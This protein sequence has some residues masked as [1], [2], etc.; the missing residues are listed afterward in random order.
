MGF[1]EENVKQTMSLKKVSKKWQ[2][3]C[4]WSHFNQW[5]WSLINGQI[6]FPGG[7]RQHVDLGCQTEKVLHRAS[8]DMSRGRYVALIFIK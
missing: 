4:M 8:Y 6:K 1:F 3:M 2:K 7:C 5:V